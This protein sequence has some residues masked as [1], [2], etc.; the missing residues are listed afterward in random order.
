M[1][2]LGGKIRQDPAGNPIIA[3]GD[4]PGLVLLQKL[5]GDGGSDNRRQLASQ[6][7]NA[8]RTGERTNLRW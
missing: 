7:T 6:A 5:Q 8:N 4:M 1:F 3:N 2:H